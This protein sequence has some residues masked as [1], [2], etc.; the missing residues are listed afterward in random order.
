[1]WDPWK[2][3]CTT[4]IHFP[5][6]FSWGNSSGFRW[7]SSCST[8]LS[9]AKSQLSMWLEYPFERCTW[10]ERWDFLKEG[11]RGITFFGTQ[12][13]QYGKPTCKEESA[14]FAQESNEALN[15]LISRKFQSVGL[16]DT[17]PCGQI[18]AINSQILSFFMVVFW[19]QTQREQT[20]GN[21]EMIKMVP[22]GSLRIP[23]LWPIELDDFLLKK[24]VICQRIWPPRP[25]CQHKWCQLW[26]RYFPSLGKI[27]SFSQTMVSSKQ[28]LYHL[29]FLE[30][31][32]IIVYHIIVGWW[33]H[34]LPLSILPGFVIVPAQLK[35][36]TCQTS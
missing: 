28:C 18:M 10:E 32:T 11:G 27:T 7:N 6:G 31:P 5:P 20:S 25:G 21:S 29:F 8:R 1:M 3:R 30:D 23:L 19:C 26:E 15:V 14:G 35:W 16:R 12:R 4:F 2:N 22:F 13:D 24:M 36:T 33:S 34:I 17:T 9:W